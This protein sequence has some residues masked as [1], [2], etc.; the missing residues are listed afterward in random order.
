MYEFTL[1]L[2]PDAGRALDD[3]A[4][5]CGRASE[6]LARDAVRR[7]LDEEARRVR[8]VAEGL[9]AAHADLLRRLGE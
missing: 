4:D 2:D 5:A 9:G 6:D 7:Y 3:L 1:R 8:V